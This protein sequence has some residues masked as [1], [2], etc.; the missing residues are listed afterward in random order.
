QS[1]D[2]EDEDSVTRSV[3]NCERV[4]AAY[5]P[6]SARAT[7]APIS[8]HRTKS[9]L[10]TVPQHSGSVS[11]MTDFYPPGAEHSSLHDSQPHLISLPC[12]SNRDG[13][14]ARREDEKRHENSQHSLPSDLL[15]SWTV[16]SIPHLRT[17]TRQESPVPRRQSTVSRRQSTVS[18]LADSTQS[19]N[20]PSTEEDEIS[21]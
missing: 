18:W 1:E 20:R 14:E 7:P 17:A 11:N 6:S 8:S 3:D 21:L 19:S 5:K 10:S 15:S 2:S 13:R 9:H 16:S 4:L 12:R